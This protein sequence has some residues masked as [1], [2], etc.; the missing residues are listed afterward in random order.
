MG[1]LDG[2]SISCFD[3]ASGNSEMGVIEDRAIYWNGAQY[4]C[5]EYLSALWE[6][7]WHEPDAIHD[8][9]VYVRVDRTNVLDIRVVICGQEEVCRLA[10]DPHILTRTMLSNFRRASWAS[11]T[12]PMRETE[13]TSG[14]RCGTA[15]RTSYPRTLSTVLRLQTVQRR[16]R[17][18]RTKSRRSWHKARISW[19]L[20]AVQAAL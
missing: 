2:I 1:S 19:T 8:P 3:V 7:G 6:S 4:P 12:R 13:L 9:S 20:R 17:D 18:H 11:D 5:S 14:L 10:E 15:S 16:T